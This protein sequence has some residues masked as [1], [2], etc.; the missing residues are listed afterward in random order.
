M[1]DNFKENI[2]RF[3]KAFIPV[4]HLFFNLANEVSKVA[5]F[6][7]AQYRMLMLIYHDGPMTITALKNRLQIAQSTASEMADRLVHQ[8][9]LFREKNPQDRRV[10]LFKLTDRTH[11][12]FQ[13]H[14]TLMQNVYQKVLEPLTLE[15]QRKLV[16]AFEIILRLMRRIEGEKR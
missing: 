4:M 13:K 11:N 10:T 16:N 1:V 8:G 2:E 15:E 7:L 5:D 9:Y 12:I 3:S 14:K 6:S